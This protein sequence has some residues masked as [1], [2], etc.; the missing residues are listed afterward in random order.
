[1]SNRAPSVGAAI[2]VAEDD[3]RALDLAIDVLRFAGY[4][5]SGA[6]SVAEAMDSVHRSRPDLVLVD[7]KL[8][9]EDGL[10]IARQLREDPVTQDIPVL[11]TSASISDADVER[12]KDAGCVSFLPKPLTP[13]ALLRSVQLCLDPPAG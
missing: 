6:G 3:P 5:A 8:G 1:V 7:I 12:A 2:L 13:R 4:V 10:D 11:A 9:P